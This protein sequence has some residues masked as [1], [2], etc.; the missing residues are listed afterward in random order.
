[1]MLTMRART[2]EAR[3]EAA[4]TLA[5][6]EA[7]TA[8][9]GDAH[10]GL[11]SLYGALGHAAIFER[12]F[13]EAER[14]YRMAREHREAAGDPAGAAMA[15]LATATVAVYRE[16][17]PRASRELRVVAAR[18]AA[19]GHVRGQVTASVNRCHVL[20]EA[21]RPAEALAVVPAMLAIMEERGIRD[22]QADALRVQA[23]AL[24]GVGRLAEAL[25]SAGAS[26]E[27]AQALADPRQVKEST[28]LLERLESSLARATQDTV[29]FPLDD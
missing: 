29:E 14:C 27:S 4:R 13:D 24:A 6:A 12:D 20:V 8:F 21:G 25:T 16:D 11:G 23:R 1:M 28:E 3:E 7:A 26:L 9:G 22:L 15:E 17:W 19:W 5:L 18:L 10:V 2:E